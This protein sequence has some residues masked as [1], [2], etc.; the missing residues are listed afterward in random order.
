VAGQPT[1]YVRGHGTRCLPRELLEVDCGYETPCHVWQRAKD[2]GGYGIMKRDGRLLSAH[3]VVWEEAHGPL[4]K[5]ARIHHLCETKACVRL[6]HLSP[7]KNHCSHMQRHA[8]KLT[9]EKAREIRASSESGVALARRYGVSR[10]EIS[11][12]RRGK[13]WRED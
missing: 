9:M 5:K 7:E 13:H 4:P 6:D 1:R 10:S 12:I 2:S 11:L 3:R 8:P